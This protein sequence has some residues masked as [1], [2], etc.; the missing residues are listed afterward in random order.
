MQHH[1]IQCL[2]QVVIDVLPH[3]SPRHILACLPTSQFAVDMLECLPVS[4]IAVD[5]QVHQGR[6]TIALNIGSAQKAPHVRI[7][8]YGIQVP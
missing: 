2:G 8:V 3:P 1:T 7:G 6:C 4:Q 5:I